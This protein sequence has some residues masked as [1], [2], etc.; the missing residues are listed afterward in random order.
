MELRHLRYFVAVAEELH[1]GRAAE[2]LRMTQPPLSQQ[3]QQLEEEL[4]AT[5]F[6]RDSRH[7]ALTDAGKVF[8]DHA[9]RTL[10]D[11]E[12]AVTEARRADRGEIGSLR[13]GFAA[14]AAHEVLPEVVRRYREGFPHVRLGLQELASGEQVEALRER[15]IDVGFLSQDVPAD[16]FQTRHI[17]RDHMLVALPDGHRLAAGEVVRLEDLREEPWLVF[18]RQN[19][20][21]VFDL[22]AGAFDRVGGRP[23][24]A[25]EARQTA[26]LVSFV[27]AGMGFCFV[28][29]FN[30]EI[31]RRGVSYVPVDDPSLHL[32]LR[33]AW[34]TDSASAVLGGFL[35]VVDAYLAARQRSASPAP[36]AAR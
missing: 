29:G 9:R 2:R 22:I 7:V 4:G 15:R 33:V 28:S 16:E 27:S 21:A 1:F 20:P 19:S 31:P 13:I 10:A 24:V 34:R 12:D 36:V 35:S 3:I 5:L 6:R 25:Q 14:N 17:L 23:V 18:P 11:A 30:R 32:D 26:T 8:L